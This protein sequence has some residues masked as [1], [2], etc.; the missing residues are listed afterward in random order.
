MPLINTIHTD[1]LLSNVA[2]K[3]YNQEYIAQKVFPVVPVKKESDL[4][5]IYTR[6]F[7]LPETKRANK[8]KAL[9]Y[10]FDVTTGAMVLEFHGL[11]DYVS[12]RDASN[13]DIF[14]LKSDTV[15]K[16]TDVIL[17]R[18]EKSVADLMVKANWSLNVSLST[19]QQ[20]NATTTANPI[21]FFDTGSSTV[22][23]NSGYMPNFIAMSRDAY[24]ST[25]NNSNVLDRVKYT[26]A[27][28]D[29]NILAK[30]FN[31][32]ELLVGTASI[33]TSALGVAESVSALWPDAA[34]LGY[35]PASA[36]P[37]QPSAGYIFKQDVPMVK[38]WRDEERSAE[39]IEVNMHYQAKVVASLAGYLIGDISA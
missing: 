8:G 21:V 11:K 31:V 16:L 3:Y 5:R 4:F 6:D 37:V 19:A 2:V 17:K 34:F 33:D 13:Y 7:R 38:R 22:L 24:I 35:R 39:A 32:G 28:M 15:E 20:W 12:D 18:L 9:E 36:S 30:L 29:K 14:D 26:S 25:K 10:S 27:E 1:T 23:Y